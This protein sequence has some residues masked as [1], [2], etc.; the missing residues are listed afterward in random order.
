MKGLKIWRMVA[1]FFCLAPA[2]WAQEAQVIAVKGVVVYR[3]DSAADW[4][5]AESGIRLDSNAE[6]KTAKDASCTLAFDLAKKNILTIKEDTILKIESVLPGHVH[7]SEGRVFALIKNIGG[8]GKFE[9]KTPTAVA[10]ARGTGWLTEFAEGET[11]VSCF[12][13][14][15][16]V[17]SLDDAGNITGEKDLTEGFGIDIREDIAESDIR[18]ITETERS[19][20]QEFVSM[21]EAVVEES[22]P[23]T[24][25]P[26][27]K[28]PSPA[29]T[30]EQQP[31][32]EPQ[33]ERGTREQPIPEQE[34]QEMMERWEKE[35]PN[36][37]EEERQ[38]MMERWEAEGDHSF[39]GF[40]GHQDFQ[41]FEDFEAM[42]DMYDQYNQTENLQDMQHLEA[43]QSGTGTP[44]P[45]PPMP[46]PTSP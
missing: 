24:P 19:E 4:K 18:E 39:E 26:E 44:P 6:I 34:R 33:G 10:G 40:E 22:A 15:V 45:M 21:I 43:E 2:A 31:V 35:H 37:T 30:Q 41:G 46:P 42:Q 36:M 9:V 17:A 14:V 27:G 8:A 12:D 32:S 29:A 1:I 5:R 3:P 13:D 28:P 16:F 38:E 11:S 25:S 23:E 7:L 20:W